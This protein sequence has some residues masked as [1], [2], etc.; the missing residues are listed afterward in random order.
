MN[1]FT[2][3]KIAHIIHFSQA[4]ELSRGTSHA[5]FHDKIQN[6]RSSSPSSRICDAGLKFLKITF[7]QQ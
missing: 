7:C 1:K 5:L 2:H 4:N 6:F 3:Y